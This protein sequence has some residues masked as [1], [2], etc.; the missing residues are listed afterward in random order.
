[1]HTVICESCKTS[2]S[3]AFFR[4]P[5]TRDFLCNS[6]HWLEFEKQTAF[7]RQ[8]S[9]ANNLETV[10]DS[11]NKLVSSAPK[12]PAR[13]TRA[14][15]SVV[16]ALSANLPVAAVIPVNDKQLRPNVAPR[17]AQVVGKGRN[18]RAL[19]KNSKS[20]KP[21]KITHAEASLCT[22]DNCFSRGLSWHRGDI[23]S[24]KDIDS[25]YIYFAQITGLLKQPDFNYGATICWLIPFADRDVE[26]LR[27]CFDPSAFVIG[28]FLNI[29]LHIKT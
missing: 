18:R 13:S 9:G 26:E 28:I 17:R 10:D 7:L 11:V 2:D 27:R 16:N 29:S 25:G 23:V 5:N 3:V 14:G 15:N 24:L 4:K 20:Q 6:C 1:M 12:Q 22:V 21:V 19:C 8:A